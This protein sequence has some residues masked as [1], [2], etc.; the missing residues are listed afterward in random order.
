MPFRPQ[1]VCRVHQIFKGDENPVEVEQR[2]DQKPDGPVGLGN[3]QI[4]SEA[5]CWL[6]YPPRAPHQ[7]QQHDYAN[8]KVYTA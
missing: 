6:H 4:A 7:G 5:F 2:D 3:S 8:E 1:G